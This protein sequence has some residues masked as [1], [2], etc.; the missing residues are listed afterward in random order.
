ML[1]AACGGETI[2][3]EEARGA[4]PGASQAQVGVPDQQG[5][6]LTAAPAGSEATSDATAPYAA[7]TIALAAAVNGGVAFTLGIV[8]LVASLPP[9]SCSGDTCTWGPGSGPLEV[10]DWQLTVTKKGEDDYVWALAGRPKT[11]PSA[12][13]TSIVS[14]EAFTTD[15]RH[16]GH[17]TL[18]VDMDA[19]A[20]LARKTTDPQDLPVG[21]ISATYD[22]TSD[23]NVSVQFLGTKDPVEPT[24]TVNAAY[25]FAAT[26]SGGDLQVA[27]RNLTTE[28]ALTLHSRWT[29]TGAGRGDAAFTLGGVTVSRSQCWDSASTL[30]NQVYQVTSPADPSSDMGSESACAFPSAQPP[31]I[32]AP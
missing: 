7:E 31:T 10:N 2:T 8:E 26:A 21:K 20:G 24:Q 19:A 5:Q 1:I 29:D 27:T 3:E 25:Q 28:A 30:F 23:R 14:G 11:D 32:T 18:V 13:F 12:G 17:G 15:V 6:A 22:N 9:T 16:V 4:V